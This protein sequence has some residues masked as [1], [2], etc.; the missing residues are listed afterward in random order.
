MAAKSGEATLRFYEELNDFLPKE[1]RKRPFR[2]RF[3]DGDTVKAVIESLG[4]PH[5]EVDLV[6]VDGQSVPFDRQVVEGNQISV[7]PVF[8][9]LEIGGLGP[10]LQGPD[11]PLPLCGKAA[12]FWTFTSAD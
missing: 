3:H 4:V 6:L 5:T 2:V 8:E 7:Y 11:V 1:G 10:L 12:L 9:S